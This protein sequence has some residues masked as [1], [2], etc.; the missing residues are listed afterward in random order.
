MIHNAAIGEVNDGEDIELHGW[1]GLFAERGNLPDHCRR[2]LHNFDLIVNMLAGPGESVS[3]N[4]QNIAADAN[5]RVI[6]IDPKPPQH[7]VGHA[8]EYLLEQ[9]PRQWPRPSQTPDAFQVNDRIL[10]GASKKLGSSLTVASKVIA[11]HPGAS[12]RA[13]CWP[14]DHFVRLMQTIAATGAVLLILGEVELERFPPDDL[15]QLKQSANEVVSCPDLADLAGILACCSGYI[16]NDSG[17]T[18]L[19]GSLGIPTVAIFGPTSAKTWQPL[20]P[21]VTTIQTNS[22]PALSVDRVL[23]SVRLSLHWQVH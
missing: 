11:V 5:C 12:A 6:H 14:A 3:Q 10:A 16:G 9:L 19:A 4:I 20:G 13:K 22:L 17:I 21:A 8:V 15:K 18:H 23:H 1:H 7:H 2:Y